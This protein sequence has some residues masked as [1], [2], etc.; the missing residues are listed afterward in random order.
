M[1]GFLF[2]KTC[3]NRQNA[4]PLCVVRRESEQPRGLAMGTVEYTHVPESENEKPGTATTRSTFI[5][6]H[7]LPGILVSTSRAVFHGLANYS[8]QAQS[9]RGPV[10]LEP[11]S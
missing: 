7:C 4:V 3:L 5:D 1:Q 8:P 6:T 10:F 2:R 11:E 9:P